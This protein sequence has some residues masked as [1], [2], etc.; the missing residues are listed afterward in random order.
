MQQLYGVDF[1]TYCEVDIKKVGIYNYAAHPS[2]RPILVAIDAPHGS[3]LTFNPHNPVFRHLHLAVDA[4][5]GSSLTFNLF[6]QDQLRI[7]VEGVQSMID[8]NYAFI[9]HNAD[10]EALCFQHLNL[11]PRLVDSAALSRALGASSSLANATMQLGVGYKMSEGRELINMFCRPHDGEALV[12]NVDSWDSDT[13]D[14]WALF[15]RYCRT[16]ARAAKLLSTI[17]PNQLN[18]DLTKYEAM[19]HAM[20]ERGWPVDLD[21]VQRMYDKSEE[22]KAAA[23]ETFRRDYDPDGKLNLN[24]HVQLKRW[25]RERSVLASSFD[26][27][28]VASM[29]ER[30]VKKLL[31]TSPTNPKYEKLSAVYRML[32]TKQ[33]VGGSS[34][35]KLPVIQRLTSEDGR[36]RG[37]YMHIGAGQSFR[38]SG[39]GVQ[40]QNLKRLGAI[41]PELDSLD[42]WN[43]D[44]IAENLRRVFT[45]SREDGQLLVGDLSSIESRGLAYLA[46]EHWKLDAYRNKLDLYKVLGAKVYGVQ[47]DDVTKAQRQTGKVG[48][49]SCGY[50]AGAGAVSSFAQKMGVNMSESAAPELVYDWRD[51]C[52]A[53]VELWSKLDRLLHRTLAVD[54]MCVDTDIAPGMVD[55]VYISLE[56]IDT[57][58]SLLKINPKAKSLVMSLHVNNSVF[59]SRYFHGCY[60]RGRDICYYK[61]SDRKTGA[62]WTDT[63]RN[64]KTKQLG[65]NKLYGG[66]LT[67]ILVQ[68]FC[69]EL[70]FRG[71][72]RAF[73]EERH[74]FQLIGQ[75]HDEL[76]VDW[77]PG[78]YT[79][80]QAQALL[81]KAM[82]GELMFRELPI[83][84]EVH[85]DF[86]YIK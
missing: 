19:T 8:E 22:N 21:L 74:G 65:Y 64:Q 2:F 16:D 58:E 5:H 26:E 46:G 78:F 44:T 43:N 62:P 14:D 9:A 34:L 86:R 18:K 55:T 77:F 69:R 36:L 41:L 38:T 28:H 52:P 56:N 31:T 81:Y 11:K 1:E 47:Y 4:S 48:E 80:G 66:K 25:C 61:P 30:V 85:S 54:G 70:F 23:L 12:D 29:K 24:S 35:K 53:T 42:T 6:D 39:T 17:M 51:Q 76:V 40:M 72:E 37:Q 73:R 71:M 60:Y 83:E 67:G 13:W 68:S 10:F 49:L 57:P 79:L 15:V 3:E 63:F 50:G 45:A 84:A 82:T 59:M 20:N 27:Q 7:F 33:V 75:F 32:R